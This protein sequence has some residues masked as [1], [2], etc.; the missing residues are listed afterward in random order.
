[1]VRSKRRIILTRVD[2]QDLFGVDKDV[3]DRQPLVTGSQLQLTAQT[4]TARLPLNIKYSNFDNIM[5]F[6]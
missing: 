1:M 4:Y 5:N 2:H 3:E 6:K